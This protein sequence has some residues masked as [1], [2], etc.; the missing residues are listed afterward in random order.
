VP[1]W[2]PRLHPWTPDDPDTDDVGTGQA[3]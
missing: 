3:I 2:R 1:A